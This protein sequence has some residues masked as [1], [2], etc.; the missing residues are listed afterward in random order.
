[1]E[2]S[3]QLGSKNQNKGTWDT[4]DCGIM[5]YVMECVYALLIILYAYL[6]VFFKNSY[7]SNFKLCDN[8]SHFCY[9]SLVLGD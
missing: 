7:A 9:F 4:T 2:E 6:S 5:A 3:K 1:M 8:V